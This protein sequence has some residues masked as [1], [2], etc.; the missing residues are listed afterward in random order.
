[1]EGEELMRLRNFFVLATLIPA[2]ASAATKLPTPEK[3]AE[4]LGAPNRW[5][6]LL[7]R[8]KPILN[9]LVAKEI[10]AFSKGVEYPDVEECGD[11]LIVRDR[12]GKKLVITL[13][14][15][16][17][18]DFNGV[19]WKLKPL[20]STESEIARIQEFLEKK[21]NTTFIDR[22][23][24]E[25]VAGGI[26]SGMAAFAYTS[27]TAWK[28]EACG[29]DKLDAE[30]SADCSLMAVAMK[31]EKTEDGFL[32]IFL[33]CPSENSG[34]FELIKKSEDG[35]FLIRSRVIYAE[36][37]PTAV[38]LAVGDPTFNPPKYN[39][40]INE[41]VSSFSSAEANEIKEDALGEANLI[42]KKVCE[43]TESDRKIYR[44][45]LNENRV[46]L[47]RISEENKSNFNSDES[48]DAT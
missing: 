21:K 6:D 23:F 34:T 25:A 42:N 20:A 36:G 1:M 14:K 17:K 11:E 48:K 18:V 35:K 9:P 47:N 8:V 15:N 3:Y 24:P 16:G 12:T 33:K 19:E 40:K 32:P 44:S 5:N 31:A 4:K 10:T 22:L 46:N 27:S 28:S 2:I 13:K 37:K 7:K 29:A 38:A 43:G 45:S 39:E 26:G 41:S 30:L